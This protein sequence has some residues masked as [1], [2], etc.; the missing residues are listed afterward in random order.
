MLLLANFFWGISF[1]TI[2]ALSMIQ[3]ELVPDGG[4]WFVTSMTVAPRFLL[5]ALLLLLFLGRSL[6]DT[7]RNEIRQGVTLGA[8]ASLGMLFQN[9]GL[10]FTQ[11]STSAF[12]TQLYAIL[13]PVWL[14]LRQR[15]NPGGWI[16][17]CCLFVLAG[18]AVL[19][20][21]DWNTLS[22]G[23]GE[24]ET[25][26]SSLFFMGQIL[27]LERPEFAGNRPERITFVMVVVEMLLF[28]GLA[29]ST[30]PRV[31]ALILPWTSPAWVGLT[32]IL[33]LFCTLAAFS[34][35][36]AWQ[37]KISSTEAG[38]I[39]CV[40]PVFGTLLSLFLPGLYSL[41]GGIAYDNEQ[42]TWSLLVGGALITL[43]NVLLQLVQRFRA[44]SPSA[45]PGT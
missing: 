3:G 11:A 42:A 22:F 29:F 20:R 30:A 10:Q 5:S 14:A 2:K 35:M 28:W 9:D 7:T 32:L 34:I 45:S 8:F 6:A 37:P 43:A 25:L 19:G 31:S 17:L 23:R 16:W 13:I 4:N 18:V 41:W 38:L 44:V 1:P 12:L 27:T 26:L 24:A 40:E 39:Y 33:T 36:N 15:R 21:F